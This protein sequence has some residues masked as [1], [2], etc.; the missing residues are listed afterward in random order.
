MGLGIRRKSADDEVTSSLIDNGVFQV[1]ESHKH[2]SD[3]SDE[4]SPYSFLGAVR[5]AFV[6]TFFLWWLPIVGPMIS[7]YVTGRKAGKP[8]IALLAASI[9]LL[10]AALVGMILNSGVFGVNTST[11]NLKEWLIAAAPIFGP[12]FQFADQYLTFYLGSIQISTGVHLDIYILT[13]AFAYLGGA[14][15]YQNYMEMGYIARHGG[16]KMTVNFHNET[17]RS[18]KGMGLFRES[19]VSRPT[20]K[21]KAKSVHSFDELQSISE[22]GVRSPVDRGVEKAQLDVLTSRRTAKKNITAMKKGSKSPNINRSG[23]R[24]LHNN[25]EDAKQMDSSDWRFI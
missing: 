25:I 3:K 16:N 10:A 5:Y 7:G 22:D 14:L 4:P 17:A 11:E 23:K 20:T 24:S 2:G 18:K 8:W 6:L 1:S 13:L 21:S 9:A 19:H 15:A 12:Y